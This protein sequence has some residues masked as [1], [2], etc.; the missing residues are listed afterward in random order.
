MCFQ[1]DLE[2]EETKAS[3]LLRVHDRF[4][5]YARVINEVSPPNVK[6][7]VGGRGP[8]NFIVSMMIANAPRIPRQNIVG[9]A[10]L[11]ECQAKGVLADT[12]S[13]NSAGIVDVT[14]WGSVNGS[15]YVDTTRAKL[16]G[17]DGAVWGPNWFAVSANETTRNDKWLE[18]EYQQLVKARTAD[19]AEKTGHSQPAIATAAA[20]TTTLKYWW[21]G[22]PSRQTFSLA[23]YSEGMTFA[24]S[25]FVIIRLCCGS[26][27]WLV[28]VSHVKSHAAISYSM[29]L[30]FL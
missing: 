25:S 1:V 8:I 29:V 9:C 27:A 12:L 17:F 5:G 21:N 6:V 4:V 13:L 22:S 7:I 2:E 14:V 20:L 30:F 28:T 11:V 24:H 19:T 15:F 10:Q 26:T 16:H 3:W 23:V 18:K